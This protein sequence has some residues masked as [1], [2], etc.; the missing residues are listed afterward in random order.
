[1]ST[2]KMKFLPKHHKPYLLN[3]SVHFKSQKEL[4][5]STELDL[6]KKYRVARESDDFKNQ[7]EIYNIFYKRYEG[8][9]MKEAHK[10][11][12][13][14]PLSIMA[15]DFDDC[16]NEVRDCLRLALNFFDPKKVGSN[17][18][19]TKFSICYYVEKQ[20][21]AKIHSFS[22][23][24]YNVWRKDAEASIS[25]ENEISKEIGDGMTMQIADQ[26]YTVHEQFLKMLFKEVDNLLSDD[27]KMV[28]NLLMEG[29]KKN[30]IKKLLNITES[31]YINIIQEI[32][33]AFKKIGINSL[34]LDLI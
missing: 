32:K 24:R 17:F 16:V 2:I 27:G 12:N 33:R 26:K 25:I 28:K 1:M 10:M 21:Q 34:E 19:S 6:C 13:R 5:N 20:V 14:I 18:D 9:I 23:K 3:Y 30:Y 22:K 15:M 4:N 11:Y 7:N 29:K 31:I 8:F